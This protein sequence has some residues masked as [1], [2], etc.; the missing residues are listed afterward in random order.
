MAKFL[1]TT[2]EE[3][4]NIIA[5]ATDKRSTV[6]IRCCKP[7]KPQVGRKD[8]IISTNKTCKYRYKLWQN[9]IFENL[10]KIKKISVLRI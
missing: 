1:K 3:L 5:Q 4:E 8:I 6:C 9:S 7:S 2:P 10:K